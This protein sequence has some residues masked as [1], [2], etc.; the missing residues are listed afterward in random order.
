MEIIQK[1][2]ELFKYTSNW[3]DN[4]VLS[5]AAG[6]IKGLGGLVIKIL[7]FLID[8]IQWVILRL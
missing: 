6:F 5:G 4:S 8:I 3:F 1:F 2:V 7:Q